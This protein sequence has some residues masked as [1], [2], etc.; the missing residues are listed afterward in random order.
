MKETTYKC[1]YCSIPIASGT[2][3]INGK[4]QIHVAGYNHPPALIYR[5][6]DDELLDLCEDCMLNAIERSLRVKIERL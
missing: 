3:L 4:V 6:P 5:A 1:D 2:G